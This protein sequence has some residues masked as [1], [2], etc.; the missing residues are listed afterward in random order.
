MTRQEWM[1]V[2]VAMARRDAAIARTDRSAY[3]SRP[4]GAVFSLAL[5]YFVS[6]L[7]SVTRFPTAE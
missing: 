1:R 5:F 6:R 3:L 7:V 2:L 4:V